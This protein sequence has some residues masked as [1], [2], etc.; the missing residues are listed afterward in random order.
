MKEIIE[1]VGFDFTESEIG[2][3]NYF[4]MN[5]RDDKLVF[6]IEVTDIDQVKSF[7]TLLPEQKQRMLGLVKN[8]NLNGFTNVTLPA[9]LWDLYIVAMH[10]LRKSQP[11]DDV[12]VSKLERDRF[13]ARKVIV[14]YEDDEDALQSIRHQL[15]PE[16]EL[17]LLLTENNQ[18]PDATQQMVNAILERLGPSEQIFGGKLDLASIEA[19]LKRIVAVIEE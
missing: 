5:I 11:F 6:F 14:E 7:V 13:L 12:E 15:L 4:F 10:D 2:T 17:D 18:E 9:F 19:Y 8:K 16:V 3:F 1:R